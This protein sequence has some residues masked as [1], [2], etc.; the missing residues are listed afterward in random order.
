MNYLLY[1]I[2]EYR[3]AL[4]IAGWVIFKFRLIQETMDLFPLGQTGDEYKTFNEARVKTYHKV[5]D[6]NP[7][8]LVEIKDGEDK[9]GKTAIIILHAIEGVVKFLFV[10]IPKNYDND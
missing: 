6:E 5:S 3:Y 10:P 7:T 4:I 8:K 1:L 9:E 2:S